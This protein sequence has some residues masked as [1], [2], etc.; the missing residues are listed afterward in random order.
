M[1]NKK[2]IV[3]FVF[4]AVLFAGCTQ[5][6]QQKNNI[7]TTD[8]IRKTRLDEIAGNLPTEKTVSTDSVVNLYEGLDSA[9]INAAWA[10]YGKV[11]PY[12]N[13]ID[14]LAG[15]WQEE[16]KFYMDGVDTP[17]TVKMTAVITPVLN[18]L[19]Q[20]TLHRGK[21]N[22]LPYEGR[23]LLGFNKAKNKFEYTWIDNFSS[24]MMFLTGDLDSVTNTINLTGTMADPV[25]GK[26]IGIR[27]TIEMI[28]NKNLYIKLYDTRNKLER[29]SMEIIMQ[30]NK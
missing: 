7:N 16:M 29:L 26:D 19:Y 20:Q 13:L 23:A 10:D 30:K 4:I 8:T 2:K 28:A 1:I 12:H 18:G 9:T 27:Q 21:V 6:Q 14:T 17:Q 25:T 5:H 3:Q 15:T 24:G 11:G 22:G